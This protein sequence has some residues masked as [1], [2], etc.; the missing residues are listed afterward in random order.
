MVTL[1]NSLFF[2]FKISLLPNYHVKYY[3]Y[4]VK[5]C[6]TVACNRCVSL[7]IGLIIGVRINRGVY[8]TKLSPL[9]YVDRENHVYS[10]K[11]L[12]SSKAQTSSFLSFLQE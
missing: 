7:D 2:V 5:W 4:I 10:S 1:L 3:D 11:L 9:N 8:G 12:K 6:S